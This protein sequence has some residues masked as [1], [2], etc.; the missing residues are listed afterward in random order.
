ME[1]QSYT[2]LLQYISF[3][4]ANLMLC[5]TMCEASFDALNVAIN[6]FGREPRRFSAGLSEPEGD[7]VV[8]KASWARLEDLPTISLSPKTP[9]GADLFLDRHRTAYPSLGLLAK[10]FVSLLARHCRVRPRRTIRS[11]VSSPWSVEHARCRQDSLGSS[12][13]FDPRDQ[14][15]L[16]G[17]S[18]D[19]NARRA[20]E[21]WNE[22]VH[23]DAERSVQQSYLDLDNM[24][25]L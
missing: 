8:L 16:L 18:L 1:G 12:I 25:R 7:D 13:D 19:T 15:I 24:V 2:N 14:D 4:P 17:E 21:D 10:H 22:D 20:I 23:R 9:P 5:C 3:H 6:P 11:E